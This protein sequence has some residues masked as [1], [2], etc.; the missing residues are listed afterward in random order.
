LV[1]PMLLGMLR[2]ALGGIRR[3]YS[4]QQLSLEECWGLPRVKDCSRKCSR[5]FKCMR[6]NHTCCWSYCGNI[7]AENNK[8]FE[9][10]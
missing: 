4:S 1:V 2:P 8:F 9:R 3:Q 5:T 6:V 10:M 7:C